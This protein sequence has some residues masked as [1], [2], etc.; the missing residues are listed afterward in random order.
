MDPSLNF[1]PSPIRRRG[2]VAVVRREHRF[3]VIRRSVHVSAPRMFCF[4]GG[5]IE[6]GEN[7]EQ[8]LIRELREELGGVV[9]PRRRLW[10]CVTRWSVSLAWW[11][12]TLE[13]MPALIANPA[14]VESIHWLT[15]EEMRRLPDMLESNHWFLQ[16]IDSGE[17]VF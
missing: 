8:A 17:I 3:L 10:H 15:V 12:S 13:A 4:P 2:V 14:E 1:E 5:G 7:E 9:V 16:A 6:A 11:E